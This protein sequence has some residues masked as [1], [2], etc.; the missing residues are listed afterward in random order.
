MKKPA[1][2]KELKARELEFKGSQEE[3]SG[4]LLE[5]VK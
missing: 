4:R 3:L 2:M 1:L 5:A